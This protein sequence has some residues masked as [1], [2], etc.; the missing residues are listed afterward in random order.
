MLLWPRGDTEAE[1][2]SVPFL[3]SQ[4]Q[5]RRL[6]LNTRVQTEHFLLFWCRAKGC[7]CK[8]HLIFR[9]ALYSGD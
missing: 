1:G 3:S 5:N 9:A 7:T 8:S 4:T 2:D 6:R